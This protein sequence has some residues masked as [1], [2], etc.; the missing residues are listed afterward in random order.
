MLT[1]VL[2]IMSSSLQGPV[3][4]MLIALVFVVAVIVGMLIAE[5]FTERRLFNVSLPD[6]I[7]QLNSQ[8]DTEQ[9]IKN[10]GLLG[11]Q[12]NCLIEFLCHPDATPSERE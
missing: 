11:R 7:D 3:I 9:V 5:V 12:K 6:M 4:V 2:H 1:E 10:S 8:D